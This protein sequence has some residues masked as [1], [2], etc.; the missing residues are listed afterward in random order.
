MVKINEETR[1]Y[2]Y[3]KIKGINFNSIIKFLKRIFS[4]PIEY[5]KK[6]F[7][8]EIMKD[9]LKA[10]GLTLEKFLDVFKGY[11]NWF[12]LIGIALSVYLCWLIVKSFIKA[13]FKIWK[14]YN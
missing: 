14:Y 11:N 9:Y 6:I 8:D 12:R 10:Y 2:F 5:F 3:E 1:K 4:N 13:L 7:S